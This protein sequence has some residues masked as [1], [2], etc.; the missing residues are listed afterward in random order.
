MFQNLKLSSKIIYGFAALIVIIAILGG[1]A[2]INMLI[3]KDKASI[4]AEEYVPEVDVA[5]RLR[6]AANR[7]MYAMRGYSLTGIDSY[8]REAE[9]EADALDEA[10]DDAKA[11]N[12]TASHLSALAAQIDEAEQARHAYFNMMEQTREL[13]ERFEA[14]RKQLDES[15]ADYMQASSEFLNLQ[16][17]LFEQ[18]LEERIAKIRAVT[19]IVDLG[20]SA[21]V[22]NF[23]SQAIGS[24]LLR[25][26][27]LEHLAEI[28]PEI[29]SIQAITRKQEDLDQLDA[30]MRSGKAYEAAI[31]AFAEESEQGIAADER[32]LAELRNAMDAAANQFVS[33]TDNFLDNQIEAMAADL[34]A[35]HRDITLVNNV[36]DVGNETRIKAF[37]AQ[38]LNDLSYIDTAL[39]ENMPRIEELLAQLEENTTDQ[40]LLEQIDGT[41]AAAGSYKQAMESLVSNWKANDTLARDRET[42]GRRLITV[43]Q[44]TAEAGMKGTQEIADDTMQSMNISSLGVGIGLLIALVAGIALAIRITKSIVDP[45]NRVVKDLQDGSEQVATVSGHVNISSQQMAEGAG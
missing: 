17:Q 24:R 7:L 15:A 23:K 35:R 36:I 9:T 8:W 1:F 6:G 21:R 40:T 37:K 33:A 39:N 11:L 34:G 14:L 44:V 28:I 41:R 12:E 38:A 27:A 4:L 22:A 2:T 29:E 19:K 45:I 10:L 16:N 18:A 32:Q 43:C 25:Q 42:A 26:E 31:K 13:Q 30:I 5:S 20:T 3:V